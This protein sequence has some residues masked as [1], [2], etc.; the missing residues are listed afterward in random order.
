MWRKLKDKAEQDKRSEFPYPRKP[1]TIVDSDGEVT[2]IQTGPFERPMPAEI[3]EQ[4]Q[5]LALAAESRPIARTPA[6]AAARQFNVQKLPRG[7]KRTREGRSSTSLWLNL[8]LSLCS[9]VGIA[10]TVLAMVAPLQAIS[11]ILGPS[12]AFVS[13]GCWWL[14]RRTNTVQ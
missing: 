7:R 4:A 3:A 12:G 5:I 11:W 13:I 1:V 6:E 10:G 9:L 8:G 2:I 14:A